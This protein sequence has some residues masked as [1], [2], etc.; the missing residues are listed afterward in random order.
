MNNGNGNNNV[1][2]MQQFM[3]A[4]MRRLQREMNNGGGNSGNGSGS[5]HANQ[6]NGPPNSGGFFNEIKVENFYF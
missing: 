5:G 4:Y 2:A 1:M 3:Q 6:S